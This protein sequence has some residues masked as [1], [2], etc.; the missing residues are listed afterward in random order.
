MGGTFDIELFQTYALTNDKGRTPTYRF[1]DYI[2]NAF[3]YVSNYGTDVS[4]NKLDPGMYVNNG[5]YN[6]GYLTEQAVLDSNNA[7]HPCGGYPITYDG[8]G[9][10]F[11]DI[12]ECNG[13]I[14]DQKTYVLL[15]ASQGGAGHTIE[16]SSDEG[17]AANY[18]IAVVE[19]G[20]HMP[21]A[22]S[23]FTRY[24]PYDDESSEGVALDAIQTGTHELGHAFMHDYPEDR[25]NDHKV[26]EVTQAQHGTDAAHWTTPMGLDHETTNECLKTYDRPGVR[27]WD[28]VWADCCQDYF[29]YPFE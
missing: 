10:Y 21:D 22:P 8:I 14:D 25:V 23:S 4:I 15:T 17:D 7:D 11:E 1:S 6:W 3:G 29:Q 20:Y 28:V 16:R 27:R 2:R 24:E 13:L 26:G 12:L 9:F 19:G 18:N 5:D